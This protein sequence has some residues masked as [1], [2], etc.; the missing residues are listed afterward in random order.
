MH[1]LELFSGTGSFKR[2]CDQIPRRPITTI[3]LDINAKHAPDIVADILEWDFTVFPTG[4]FDVIWASPEC[5]EYSHAK[6]RGTR[7]LQKADALVKRTLRIIEYFRPKAWF[8]ENPQTGLLKSRSFM[9]SLPFY[10]VTYCKYGYPYRKKTRIW[11]N[12]QGF[13]PKV[14][15]RD[16]EYMVGNQH[17]M[18]LGNTSLD[19]RHTTAT[20]SHTPI[21]LRSAIPQLLIKDLMIASSSLLTD[22]ISRQLTRTKTKDVDWSF[23]CRRP[24]HLPTP[25]VADRHGLHHAILD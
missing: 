22:D 1:A 24:Q 9:R 18:R 6:T 21:V 25:A 15:N 8:V 4:Y 10:D 13:R 7:D 5:T 12:V 16:C 17:M 14:C 23:L 11:T 3:T 20:T 2:F 19:N